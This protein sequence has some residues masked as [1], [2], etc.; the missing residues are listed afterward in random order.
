VLVTE[1]KVVAWLQDEVLQRT[2]TSSRVRG[3]RRQPIRRSLQ[4]GRSLQPESARG[5]PQLP[6]V[7]SEVD[8]EVEVEAESSS[9]CTPLKYETV[10]V[11]IAAIAELYHAQ[12]SIGSN[13]APSF[14]GA[15]FKGLMRDLQ[16]TQEKRARETFEDRGASGI[17]AGYTLE[18]FLHIQDQLL[19]STKSTIQVGKHLYNI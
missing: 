6:E 9:R 7:D 10:K 4:P 11:Y 2:T 19:S 5:G 3:S 17:A 18:E 14:R 8:S 1:S 13:Q 12:V 16:R 15:A